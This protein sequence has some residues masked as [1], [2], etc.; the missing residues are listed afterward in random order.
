MTSERSQ[1]LALGEDLHRSMHGPL[2]LL[3]LCVDGH[4]G[5]KFS[6]ARL[7]QSANPDIHD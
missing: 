5:S 6:P 2:R 4:V 3:R 7:V 1:S